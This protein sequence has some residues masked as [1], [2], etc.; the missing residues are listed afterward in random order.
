MTGSAA[1]RY[2]LGS[3]AVASAALVVALAATARYGSGD[4]AGWV[5]LGWG[6][7][8]AVGVAGGAWLA[9]AHGT[10]GTDFLKALGTCILTRLAGAAAGAAWAGSQGMGAVWAYLAGLGAGFVSLQLFEI[11]WFLRLSRGWAPL[12]GRDAVGH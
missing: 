2:A 1:R 6:V 12:R 4:A 8:T 9:S 7:T 5:L 3:A 11:G 10:L